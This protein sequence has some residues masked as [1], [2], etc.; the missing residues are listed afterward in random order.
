MTP[1][2]QTAFVE[3]NGTIS[4]DGRWLMLQSEWFRHIRDLRAALS[5][6][7]QR[8]L[9]GVHHG[10]HA[11]GLG[12]QRPG[13]TI[14]CFFVGCADEGRSAQRIR[15]VANPADAADQGGLLHESE[16]VGAVVQHSPDGQRF[17]DDREGAGE[18]SG[19][20]ASIVVVLNWVDELTRRLQRPK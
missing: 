6:G 19:S 5:R 14:L 11:A 7:Q 20:P 8:S 13:A 12:A 3:R 2:V 18:Q 1:L 17:S 4:P 10:G 9:A 15:V 16:L